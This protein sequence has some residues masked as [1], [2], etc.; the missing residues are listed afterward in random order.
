MGYGAADKIGELQAKEY[1]EDLAAMA[2]EYRAKQA[3]GKWFVHIRK[4][5][6]AIRIS[7]C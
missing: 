2:E 6:L 7:R 1:E 5:I 4:G 3:A